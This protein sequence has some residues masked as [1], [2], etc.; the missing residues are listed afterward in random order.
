M[1]V[2]AG[3]VQRALRRTRDNGAQLLLAKQ[4]LRLTRWGFAVAMMSSEWGGV[5]IQTFGNDNRLTAHFGQREAGC[6]ATIAELTP[7]A[8]RSSELKTAMLVWFKVSV[9]KEM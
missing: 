4:T 6:E 7:L 3:D 8:S 2:K 9:A 1:E 5:H